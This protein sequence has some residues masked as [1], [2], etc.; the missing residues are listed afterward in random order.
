[1][2]RETSVVRVEQSSLQ[3]RKLER[4]GHLSAVFF[5]VA[6]FLAVDQAAAQGRTS[7]K[8]WTAPASEAAKKNPVAANQDSIGAGE[9]VYTKRCLSCHGKSGNGDGPDAADLGIHPAKFSDPRLRKE[10][11][12]A[13]YWKITVGKKPMPHYGGRLS[14]ADRWNV[15][16]YIRTLAK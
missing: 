15:I 12:G 4:S 8:V 13:F 3:L 14:E 11:D 6:F 2:N 5:L 1:M 9:K 16:N 7:E 10:S